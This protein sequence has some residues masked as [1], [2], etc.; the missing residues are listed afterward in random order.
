MEKRILIY[1]NHFSPE[2]FKINEVVEWLIE[3][4]FYVHVITGWPNYP[5]GKI[6]KGYG[7]LKKSFEIKGRLSIVRLPLIPRGSGAKF[8]L[9]LNYLSYFF[10]TFFYTIY[11]I[12]LSKKYEKILVHHTSPFFLAFSAV[13]Y[14]KIKNSSAILWD[15]DMWP[16]TL[17]AMGIINSPILI[18]ILEKIVKKIYQAFDIIFVSS[19]SFESIAKKRVESFKIEYFPN[20]ADREFEKI[21][22]PIN[23]PKNSDKIIITYAGNLGE[24]QGLDIVIKSIKASKNENLEFNFIGSG[25]DKKRLQKLVETNNLN[26]NFIDN[27]DPHELIPHF[28]KTHY[29][30]LSLKDSA[31]FHKTVPAKLQTYLAIGKPIISSVS[32]E[33][34][35]LL[36]Q[37]NCGYCTDGG[38]E[39]E[40]TKIFE[41]LNKT[42]INTYK[43]FSENSKTLYDNMFSSKKRKKQ[44]LSKI[45]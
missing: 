11:L 24:A 23:S 33:T 39:K 43:T 29:L 3:S 12:L 9:L 37:N 2:N 8:R 45:I 41:T 17:Q 18:E 21:N 15:L 44:L 38:N 13:L 1:T 25:R 42:S 20:W 30:F 7:F 27:I 36:I 34:K 22:L 28:K 32:G 10:S 5:G 31:I 19:K 16:H 4:G 26:I 40:L 14:K 35:K 6:F